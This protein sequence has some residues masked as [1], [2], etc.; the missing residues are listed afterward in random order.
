MRKI[1]L[2][3]LLALF[4]CAMNPLYAADGG[5]ESIERTTSG[6]FVLQDS[7]DWEDLGNGLRRQILGYDG[8]I[9]MVKLQATKAGPVGVRHKHYH[10]QVTYVSSGRFIFTV[11]DKKQEVKAGDGIYMEP[12]VPHDCYC[13]EPGIIVDCFAP[14][15]ADFLKK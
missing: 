10:S 14:M 5:G 1:I 13:I 12:D 8:H 7:K 2:T 6:P 15:R 11:G 3:A 4:T 9:M